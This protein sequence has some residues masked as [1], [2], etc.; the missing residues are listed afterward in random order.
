LARNFP[1]E[2]LFHVHLDAL[3]D[4]S[5]EDVLWGNSYADRLEKVFAGP[6]NGGRRRRPKTNVEAAVDVNAVNQSAGAVTRKE[7]DLNFVRLLHMTVNETRSLVD[8]NMR[9]LSRLEEPVGKQRDL[10]NQ[11]QLRNFFHAWSAGDVV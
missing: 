8:Q 6:V 2:T 5:H 11:N 9:I 1:D 7:G 10:P 4:Q 3:T